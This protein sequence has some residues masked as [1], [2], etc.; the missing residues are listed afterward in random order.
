MVDHLQ[1]ATYRLQHFRKIFPHPRRRFGVCDCL[2]HGGQLLNGLR[3]RDAFLQRRFRIVD[4]R[5][6]GIQLRYGPLHLVRD[7]LLFRQLVYFLVQVRR[8]FFQL[9]PLLC[10]VSRVCRVCRGSRVCGVG[11][12]SGVCWACGLGGL[13]GVGRVSGV[14]GV[15]RVVGG[16]GLGGV[17][18]VGRLS[19]LSGVS[20]FSRLSRVSG[21]SGVSGFS[22]DC[23]LSWG[24]GLRRFAG[25][26]RGGR[27]GGV[28]GLSRG[29]WVSWS[30]WL[31]LYG[32]YS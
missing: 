31:R 5:Q 11:R 21:V 28:C 3:E 24:G 25:F 9:L 13:G 22:R 20:G 29:G 7:L 12:V 23:G 15:S 6:G 30:R 26:S 1:R 8:E 19:G 14:S 2:H 16:C 32:R 17:C 10:G 4:Y 27:L 18:R